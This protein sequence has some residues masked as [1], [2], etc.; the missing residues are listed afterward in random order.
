MMSEHQAKQP[1]QMTLSARVIRADGRIEELGDLAYYYRNPLK[2]LWY[3]W[4]RGVK[5]SFRPP[6]GER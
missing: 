4:V 3:R 6:S 5:G 1:Q 2:R